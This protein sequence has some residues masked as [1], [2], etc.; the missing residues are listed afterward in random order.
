MSGSRLCD[1]SIVKY[2]IEWKI[3]IFNVQSLVCSRE[4]DKG[5]D[6]ISVQ[7]GCVSFTALWVFIVAMSVWRFIFMTTAPGELNNW[8]F[9]YCFNSIL[10][11]IF[12]SKCKSKIVFLA[13][14]R[15]SGRQL[16]GWVI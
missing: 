11:R 16:M 6:T 8:S 3:K 10:H 7:T 5:T 12:Q 9:H 13:N 4:T 1:I 15:Q 2:F 14:F